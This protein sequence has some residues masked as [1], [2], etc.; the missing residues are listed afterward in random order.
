MSGQA[1]FLAGHGDG[2][3]RLPAGV[4]VQDR[5]E[6]QRVRRLVEIPR[7]QRLDHIGD[8]VLLD[9]SIR[10]APS[11]APESPMSHPVS[12][13]WGHSNLRFLLQAGPTQT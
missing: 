5:V 12:R 11:G 9:I 13:R 7:P 4:Q 3:R 10:S 6:H 1:A 8:G 2:V